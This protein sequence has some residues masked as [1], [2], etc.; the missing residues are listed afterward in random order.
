MTGPLKAQSEK[1]VAGRIDH[2][3][4]EAMRHPIAIERD[5]EARVV[6]ISMEEYERLL[7]RDREVLLVKDPDDEMI[8]AIRNVRPPARSRRLDHLMDDTGAD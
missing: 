8:E 2:Y 5:G 1:E 6:M 7:R 3:L 4:D